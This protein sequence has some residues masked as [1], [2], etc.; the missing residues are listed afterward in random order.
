M[1]TYCRPLYPL[2]N[3]YLIFIKI[4]TFFLLVVIYSFNFLTTL[5]ATV[6]FYPLYFISSFFHIVLDFAIILSIF[7]HPFQKFN[8]LIIVVP[9]TLCLCLFTTYSSQILTGLHAG[10]FFFCSHPIITLVYFTFSL[11]FIFSPKFTLE[12]TK[13][14]YIS[15]MVYGLEYCA[16][17]TIC[18]HSIIV[19]IAGVF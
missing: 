11:L 12:I 1:E 10:F 8:L 17:I 4:T 3:I 18:I 16:S 9:S 15:T 14:L 6:F 13:M 2:P 7:S 19:F 5:I